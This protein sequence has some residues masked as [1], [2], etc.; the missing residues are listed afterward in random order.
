MDK[1]ININLGGMLF[2]LDEAAYAKLKDYLK[3][4]NDRFRNT[5]GGNETIDDIEN[6]IA[7][8]FMSMKGTAGV[9]TPENVDEMIR[10]MGKPEDFEN[11]GFESEPASS[12]FGNP[13][14]RKR[15]FRNH[16]NQVIS[17][18][19]GGIGAYLNCDPVWIR[20]LF[21]LFAC[22]FGFGIFAYV[23]LWIA[24]PV[25][26]SD[27]QKHEMYGGNHNW[28]MPQE[29]DQYSGSRV[30]HALNEVFRAIGR[31]FYIIMRIILIIFGTCIAVTGF[32]G[33]FCF[34]MIFVFK[35]PGT[36]S[37]DIQ[38]LNITYLPD[39][40]NYIVSQG[41][42]PW[43]RILI[44]A[45]VTL[46]LFALIYGGIRL[47]F[48][49]R[50]R[51]GFFWLGGFLLWVLCVTALSIVLFNEGVSFAKHA[52]TEIVDSLKLPSDTIYISAGAT[53]SGIKS[54]NEISLP[55]EGGRGYNI[56]IDEGKKQIAIKSH[57]D[58]DASSDKTTSIRIVKH[59]AGRDRI[60]AEKNAE[61]L[62]YNYKVSS[63]SLFLDE[64]FTL[65]EGAKWSMDYVFLNLNI[66]VGTI[67]KVD[68]DI[69]ETIMRSGYRNDDEFF[70]S[71]G[72]LVMTE[73]GLSVCSETKIKGK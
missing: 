68:K 43:I 27:Q 16:E 57:L 3:A 1:T 23:A 12:V 28:A 7:E 2:Q 26:V 70:H 31:V 25:A 39:F 14:P 71:H 54:G 9:I 45:A 36:F 21:V 73:D 52:Q 15:M 33:F 8:I 46:P 53:L 22:F 66:P 4:I 35:Y 51:D 58:F 5:K 65:P 41:A 40:L 61:R 29:W 49:F 48:W 59:S 30:G 63:D 6:R 38:G 69:M 62:I 44:T 19:C 34:I 50:V 24:L 67:V 47:I 42:A 13:G 37:A 20:L 72:L 17:G 55:D 32:I 18:V 64:Y 10:I 11:P 60:S 56:F